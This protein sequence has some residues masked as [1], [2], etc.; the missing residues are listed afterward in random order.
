MKAKDN[1]FRT[2]SPFLT[3]AKHQANHARGALATAYIN[4]L[5]SSELT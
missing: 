2:K 4:R 3:Y 5:S 1:N